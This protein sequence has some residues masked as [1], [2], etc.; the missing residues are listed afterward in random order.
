MDWYSTVVAVLNRSGL[1]NPELDPTLLCAQIQVE[2]GGNEKAVSSDGMNS[3][4]LFQITPSFTY[5]QMGF[6]N[7]ADYQN[8]LKTGEYN[9]RV[10]LTLLSYLLTHYQSLMLSGVDCLTAMLYAWNAGQSLV[11]EAISQAKSNNELWNWESYVVQ[12]IMKQYPN[13][14][15]MRIMYAKQVFRWYFAFKTGQ[16]S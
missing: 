7:V 5:N 3:T 15:Q 4:G 12:A 16:V 10:A 9:I 8:A 14:Q 2:S 11:D 13:Q 1:M 6:E